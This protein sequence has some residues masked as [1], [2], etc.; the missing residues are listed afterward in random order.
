MIALTPLLV[1]RLKVIAMTRRWLLTLLLSAAVLRSAGLQQAAAQEATA[2]PPDI[3]LR[4][5]QLALDAVRADHSGTF[6]P[7]IHGGPTRTS[8][9][10]AIVHLAMF[11]AANSVKKKYTPYRT[12]VPGLGALASVNAAVAQAGHD[13]LASLYPNQSA[14]FDAALTTDLNAVTNPLQ[15]MTGVAIGKFVARSLLDVRSRDGASID[16]TYTAGT[17]P[18]QHRPDP[19]HLDQGFLTPGWGNVKPFGLISGKQFRALPPPKL[20][21]AQ[22]AQAF[23]EVQRL[24]GDGVITPTERTAEQTLIGTYWGYDGTPNLGCTIR[25]R[26]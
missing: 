24:G 10:L 15:R 23:D 22:Y 3:V 16:V 14:V 21:S 7:A 17:L 2:A 25:L 18:G 19:F 8:R 20:T 11:D 6:G 13:T 5:N 9:A 4:W 26:A 12:F 1:Q